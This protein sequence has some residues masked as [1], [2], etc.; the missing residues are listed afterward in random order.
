MTYKEFSKEIVSRKTVIKEKIDKK[1]FVTRRRKKSFRIKAGD[2]TL[3]YSSS[4]S[5]FYPAMVTK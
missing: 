1:E 2:I 4:A 3:S 5:S